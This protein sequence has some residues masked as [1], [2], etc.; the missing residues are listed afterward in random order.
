MPPWAAGIISAVG[1]G[2]AHSYQGK[3][4]VPQVIAVGAVF[5]LLYFLTGSVWV[6]IVVHALVDILQGKLA[7]EV[8]THPAEDELPE[9]PPDPQCT[10]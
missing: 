5:T 9:T 2:L 8:F 6:P 3:A 1:F 10:A 7:F 4:Q